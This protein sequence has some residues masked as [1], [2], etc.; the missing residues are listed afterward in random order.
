MEKDNVLSEL[1]YEYY[2]S[3]I[4]FGIYKYGDQLKSVSQLCASF[5]LAR[6]T[7]QTALN[8]LEEK[9]Y[10]RTEQRR[11][12]RVIYQGN[13]KI[14]KEN[15]EKYFVPR[16]DGLRDIN[17]WGQFLFSPIWEKGIKNIEQSPPD[18][19]YGKQDLMMFEATKLYYDALDT[20]NNRLMSSL[21]WQLLRYLN[22]FY[23]DEEYETDNCLE[24][25]R[26][27]IVK[28]NEM[29]QKM[30]SY[31]SGIYSQVENFVDSIYRT[32]HPEDVEQ[33]PF[34]WTIYRKRPQVRYTLASTILREIL[35]GV[36]PLGSYLP[37]LPQMAEQYQVSL[38]TVRRTLDVLHTFGVTNTYKGVGTQ[39]CLEPIDPNIL[40]TPE[41]RE[42]L[43]LY[44]EGI[45]FFA[46]TVHNVTFYTLESIPR[47][48]REVLLQ[49]IGN[50]CDKRSSI[51]CMDV[52]LNFISTEAPSAL[53]RE[54]YG[55]LRELMTWGYV[56]YA[57]LKKT[58]EQQDN[59]LAGFITQLE[60]N[61]KADNLTA[62]AGQWQSFIE[63]RLKL[64]RSKILLWD[65][66][67][68]A[69]YE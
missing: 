39:V 20:L 8:K 23:P 4:C 50:L 57:I 51:L 36:Y 29:K 18:S 24:D 10:I 6:N 41:I 19:M 43:L 12:A 35:W 58:G 37:S 1:I 28:A 14:F 25:G 68:K 61:L 53:F 55:K 66:Q 56:F 54:C 13:P 42:N 33:I 40:S 22:Y 63:D 17:Q 38:I 15:V 64:F 46:L 32:Y 30:D 9:G 16:R 65:S 48:K 59:D 3:R 44:G 60:T 5:G 2:K 34:T 11:M 69:Q 67:K 27:S 21:Y 62:F 7:V 31:Y 49:K 45:E 26:F 52:L 47:D